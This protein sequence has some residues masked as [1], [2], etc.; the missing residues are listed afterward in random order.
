MQQVLEF[1]L[2]KRISLF[3]SKAEFWSK[4]TE[5]LSKKV[6]LKKS[7]YQPFVGLFS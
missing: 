7:L 2:Y 4:L 1:F 5:F 6:V 3:F